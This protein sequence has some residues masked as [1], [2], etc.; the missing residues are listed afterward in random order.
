MN[1]KTHTNI[2]APVLLA[3]LFLV[4][5]FLTACGS[6]SSST[7]PPESVTISATS[8]SG[9]S[10]TVGAAFGNHLV[11]TVRT[12]GSVTSGSTVTFTAPAT[13]ASGTFS[14]GAATTTATTDSSG[15]ASVTFTANTAAGAYNVTASTPAASIP[16]SFSFTNTAGSAAAI[17]ATAGATQSATVTTAFTTVLGA[18]VVD[19]DQ[20]PVSGVTVTFTAPASGPTGTFA[21]GTNTTTATTD[22]SGV[23]SASA[24]TANGTSGGPYTVTA[25]ASG[26]D[27]PANFALTNTGGVYSFYLSGLE[28]INATLGIP[29]YYALAGSVIIDA[30]GNVLGGEQD[31]ND[32]YGLTY[33]GSTITPRTGALV[34]WNSATAPGMG[35]LALN[36]TNADLDASGSE[37]LGVQFVNSSHALIVEYDDLATSSGSMDLQTL[38]STL[39]GNYAFTVSGVDTNY[40]PTASGG[41]FSITGA[42]L[43]GIIDINDN[44]TVTMGTPFAATVSAPDS[45]GRGSIAD[46]SIP[47]LYYYIIGPEAIRIINMDANDSAVG[48]AFG[49]GPY[50]D[51]FSNAMLGTSVFEIESNSYAYPNYAALGM[52]GT[53]AGGT[54]SG[55]ADDDEGGIV[56]P[57]SA[58]S[59]VYTVNSAPNGTVYYGYGTLNIQ[60]GDLGDVSTLGLYMTDPNLNLLDPNNTDNVGSTTSGA[61]LAGLDPNPA[62]LAG[63]GILV[64]QTDTAAA[65]F[66]GNYAFG[67]QEFNSAVDFWEWDFVG[68][69]P[70]TFTVGPPTNALSGTGLV[71]DP[72]LFFGAG[73]TN[74]G[75]GISGTAIPDGN[76]A[77]TG[78]YTIPLVYTLGDGAPYTVVIYQASGSQLF[79]LNEDTNSLFLGSL[80][81]QGSFTGLPGAKKAPVK[82]TKPK[83]K[84]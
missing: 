54:F 77:D 66:T 21:N 13:G 51:Q 7:T 28:A 47:T 16:A 67:A 75:V 34:W 56:Y 72:G 50:F 1:R 30:N 18:T 46:V 44:G 83:P 5:A 23:A 32:A 84:Q 4:F 9:Q 8:G 71:S 41:V 64:P 33:P 70:V 42:S 59:G 48:S 17:T 20:N 27:T 24:F 61:L 37:I 19:S 11:A 49:Q 10:A 38:P 68:Q 6:S 2:L 74:G 31:Y 63:T 22:S 55:V 82:S 40:A 52:F 26:V 69:G 53:D 57:L 76:E 60:A 62:P 3:L 14:G 43:Q 58:I 45:F 78:R 81:Q 15:V 79:W 12:N 25:T 80:Q 29:N 73:E 36:W 39:T 35:T 65:D